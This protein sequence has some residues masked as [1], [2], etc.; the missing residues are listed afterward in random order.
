[1]EQK[2]LRTVFVLLMALG[3][4]CAML[5]TVTMF[6]FNPGGIALGFRV[7]VCAGL[8]VGFLALFALDLVGIWTG[9][10]PHLHRH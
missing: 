4:F 10:W 5:W 3:A 6:V 7:V 1:M 8:T 2:E 9:H